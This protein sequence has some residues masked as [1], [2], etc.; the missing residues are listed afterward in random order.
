[1]SVVQGWDSVMGKEMGK[2]MGMGKEMGKAMD[3]GLLEGTQGKAARHT[4]LECK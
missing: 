4:G 3:W 2:G 1:M